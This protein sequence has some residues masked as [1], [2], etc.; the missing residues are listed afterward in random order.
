MK[1]LHSILV[2]TVL[3][4]D[5]FN[6]KDCPE[7][8]L[9]CTREYR[10]ICGND[11]KT[12]GSACMARFSFCNGN[13]NLE[14]A[15]TGPCPTPPTLQNEANVDADKSV[16]VSDETEDTRECNNMCTK[17]YAPVCGSDNVKYANDCKLKFANCESATEIRKVHDGPC[18]EAIETFDELD[19]PLKCKNASLGKKVCGNNGVTYNSICHLKKD[20]CKSEMTITKLHKGKCKKMQ[21]D[22]PV[23]PTVPAVEKC[24]L[25][26]RRMLAPV[27]GSDYQTYGNDCT[28]RKFACDNPDRALYQLHKGQC[29]CPDICPNTKDAWNPICGTDNE[30]YPSPCELKRASCE[31]DPTKSLGIAKYGPC[32]QT[33]VLVEPDNVQLKLNKCD[34]PESMQRNY[35]PICGKD[36]N[37]YQNECEAKCQGTEMERH[38][39]CEL[40]NDF[41]AD[42]FNDVAEENAAEAAEFPV[43]DVESGMFYTSF[44]KP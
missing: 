26:C 15:H 2:G 12:Y 8:G 35:A 23:V 43:Y 31:G 29:E 13:S 33:A 34:C 17:E 27:C 18:Q 37:T 7:H 14:I 19:C 9:P 22:A 25:F 30:D 40:M 24:P 44:E 4:A 20:N 36:G 3:A 39:A 16:D 41:M 32:D 28:L 10:P 1:I 11:G 38:G 6:Q 21:N 5:Q 42:F